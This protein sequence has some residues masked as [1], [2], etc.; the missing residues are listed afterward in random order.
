MFE[1]SLSYECKISSIL[2]RIRQQSISGL[3]LLSL[4]SP[5]RSIEGVVSIRDSRFITGALSPVDGI[6]GYSALKKLL[7]LA[8]GTYTVSQP[9]SELEL[10]ELNR[11]DHDI[12]ID[13]E[14]IIPIVPFLPDNLSELFDQTSLL[15][16][17]F[18][19]TK[20][21]EQQT[22]ADGTL[23]DSSN[24]SESKT[25]PAAK[26][27]L[28]ALVNKGGDISHVDIPSSYGERD[29]LQETVRLETKTLSRF[30]SVKTVGQR[31]LRGLTLAL[32]L[33]AV[34]WSFG[35]IL[36]YFKSGPATSKA[37]SP[38]AKR[39]PKIRHHL[40]YREP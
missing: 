37:V 29:V 32:M 35:E 20:K 10:R 8:L 11:F 40:L 25:T 2:E 39:S 16:K 14:R 36:R 6:S 13:V 28:K 5:D 38:I 4:A 24:P 31:I 1:G 30:G 27:L 22:T 33:V 34:I 9:E 21:I 19:K 18:S 7:T 17:V 26:S 15:D 23:A 3:S 12:N